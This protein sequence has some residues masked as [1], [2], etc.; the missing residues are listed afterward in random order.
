MGRQAWS[1]M[2]GFTCVSLVVIIFKS[3]RAVIWD[4]H[5]PIN[6]C[7]G[8]ERGGRDRHQEVPFSPSWKMSASH[9]EIFHFC[10]SSLV[11]MDYF[12]D[13]QNEK[14]A[15]AG[16]KDCVF[17][18]FPL[19]K[20]LTVC[21]AVLQIPVNSKFDTSLLPSCTRYRECGEEWWRSVNLYM[22]VLS[23][24]SVCVCLVLM[25]DLG[26]RCEAELM[27]LWLCSQ[28]VSKVAVWWMRLTCK[29]EWA[30]SKLRNSEKMLVGR[31]SRPSSVRHDISCCGWVLSVSVTCVVSLGVR[32]LLPVTALQQ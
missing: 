5:F 22:F 13:L 11:I 14:A 7:W 26:S 27:T 23:T 19:N 29:W 17:M 21:S 10:V 8:W 20:V 32:W 4:W 30:A 25:G 9:F 28:I 16:G 6:I 12:K 18:C 24:S 3:A 15:F 2:Q 1:R 31:R